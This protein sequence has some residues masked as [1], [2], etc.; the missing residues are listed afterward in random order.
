MSRTLRNQPTD[1]ACDAGGYGEV[2]R[3]GFRDMTVELV[4]DFR[5]TGLREHKEYRRR[6]RR[7]L[8]LG[9]YSLVLAGKKRRYG[10]RYGSYEW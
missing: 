6:T 8:R 2:V 1:R 7:S 5:V 3:D 4:R 10:D 9:D